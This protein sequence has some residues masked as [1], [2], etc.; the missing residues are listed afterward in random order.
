MSKNLKSLSIIFPAYNEQENIVLAIQEALN[1]AK[2]NRINSEIIIVDDGSTDATY[3]VASQVAKGD[4]RL[5]II[6]HKKNQGYGAAVYDGLKA[7]KGDLIFFTDSDLQFRFAELKKFLKEIEVY[8]A[9]IG[10]RV[11]R[12]EGLARKFNAWGWRM[13]A[14]AMLSLSVRD[15]DCAFKLF[16]RDVIKNIEVKSRGATFSA[17]LLYRI[18]K[19]GYKIKELSVSHFPRRRGSP[20]GARLDVIA[21]AFKEIWTLYLR[22]KNLV[23][24][25]SAAVFVLSIIILFLS[26]VLLMSNSADFFDSTQYAWRA[27]ISNMLEVM[28]TGHAPFHPLYMFFSSLAY[29]M[30]LAQ[31]GTLAANIPSVI[32]G[33]LS[34]IVLYLLIR[35]TINNRIA[36]LTALLY[37]LVPFVWVSQITVLVDPVEHFFYFLS[38]YFS[39]LSIKSAKRGGYI[40]ALFSGLSFGLAAFAHT[41]VALWITGFIFTLTVSIRDLKR[42]TLVELLYKTILFGLGFAVF[43]YF[44]L[45]LLVYA[46]AKRLDI[47]DYNYLSALKYLLMGNASDR[48]VFSIGT[49]FTSTYRLVVLSSALASILAV[50]GAI[51]MFF[52]DKRRF[53]ALFFYLVPSYIIAGSYIYENLYG[54]A[55][56]IALVP[57]LVFASYF[58]LSQKFLLKTVLVILTLT[59]LIVLSLPAVARYH[60]LPSANEELARL[61]SQ[62][63]PNGV[64]IGTNVT[65]TYRDYKSEFIGFG[66]V[67]FGAGL[68]IEKINEALG[69]GNPAFI[70]SDAIYFPF[71]RFDGLNYDIR[72]ASVG[73]PNDHSTLLSEL[74][75]K[76]NIVLTQVS[77]RP[78]TQNIFEVYPVRDVAQSTFD[79]QP[80]S[81]AISNGVKEAQT[82]PLGNIA[83]LAQQ[84]NVVFG[85][86]VEEQEPITNAVVNVLEPLFCNAVTEDI[87]RFD[88]IFCAKR[89]LTGSRQPN[90]W[91]ISDRDGW[92]YGTYSTEPSLILATNPLQTRKKNLNG[93]FISKSQQELKGIKLA[94]FTDTKSLEAFIKNLPGSFYVFAEGGKDEIRY[95]VFGLRINISKTNR[96]EGEDFIGEITKIKKAGDASADE[97]LST[98][99]KAGYMVSGPYLKLDK[100]RYKTDFNVRSNQ[101]GADIIKFEIASGFGRETLA[102]KKLSLSEINSKDFKTLTLEFELNNPAEGIEFRIQT[103]ASAK[104]DLDYLEL[105]PV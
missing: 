95:R 16:R 100:G 4:E 78:F 51:K 9:V 30:G 61:E 34:V 64:F 32:F 66:D 44:Y 2:K 92:F 17:E 37:A 62:A 35:T 18:K 73:G 85:R 67:G 69:K 23:C 103:P 26:R 87:T 102:Q 21:R 42:K 91:A 65:K 7:A 59:Q 77:Q 101:A 84:K 88:F 24:S 76:K 31:S 60:Y 13:V 80:E 89:Y 10:Y 72:S 39:V 6:S 71:R 43:I 82:E 12:S 98:A 97:V 14:R 54:R 3:E 81:S 68:A 75:A 74:F 50:L 5:K 90:S 38:L 105:K 8:D 47:D 22:D 46:G 56:I 53:F 11:K 93:E 99:G 96:L 55:L 36:W 27:V 28:T 19:K 25:R 79:R 48:D 94:E 83:S 15:V 29:K 20:T 52:K 33:P 58:I 40:L 49:V 104:V 86:V 63:K 41:Q 1:F 57:L 70:A 45:Y